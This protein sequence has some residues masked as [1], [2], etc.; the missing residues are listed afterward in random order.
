MEM[1]FVTPFTVSP[2]VPPAT[3]SLGERNDPDRALAAEA[4]VE[5]VMA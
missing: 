5:T 2:M 4:T 1:L 3:V